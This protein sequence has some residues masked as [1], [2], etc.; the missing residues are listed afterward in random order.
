LQRRSLHINPLVAL[1]NLDKIGLERHFFSTLLE[2]RTGSRRCCK[3][4]GGEDQPTGTIK[5]FWKSGTMPSVAAK[6]SRLVWK[7]SSRTSWVG[8]LSRKKWLGVDVRS[9]V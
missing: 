3:A 1:A 8:L 4:G 9:T 5:R 6:R 7:S 2:N